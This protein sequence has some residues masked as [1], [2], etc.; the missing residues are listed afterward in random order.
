LFVCLLVHLFVLLNLQ[1]TVRKALSPI[2]YKARVIAISHEADLAL[3]D[4]E[5]KRFWEG[6]VVEGDLPVEGTLTIVLFG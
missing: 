2:A 4:V 3:L 1:V 6:N 5:D